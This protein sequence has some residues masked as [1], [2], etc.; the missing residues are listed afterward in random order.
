MKIAITG[1]TGFIGRTLARA[2]AAEGHQIVLIARGKDSTDPGIRT[3]RGV[4]FVPVSLNE[5]D[6]LVKAFAGCDAIA[7]CAGINREIGEHTFQRVHVEATRNVVEAAKAAG[8][9][10]VILTSFLRARPDCGSLYHESK[11]AAEEI[12]RH[13]DLNYTI[14]KSGVIYGKSDHMLDHLSHAFCT[15]PVFGFVGL[16]DQPVRPVAVE[17][18]VRL[19]KAAIVDGAMPRETVAVIGPDRLMLRDVVRQVARVVGKKPLMV[20][21]PLWF[22]YA[23]AK[24]IERIMVVPMVSTAQVRMLSEGIAEACPPAELPLVE[25]APRTHFT[26]EQIRLGLPEGKPFGLQDLICWRNCCWKGAMP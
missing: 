9:G 22:H 17:D 23:M 18:F 21:M 12:V 5:R 6:A 11:W 20:P 2:L 24:V 4:Q 13:S 26:D 16:K 14:F 19:M 25:L 3:E 1:G 15:F 7:H 10:K 8:V